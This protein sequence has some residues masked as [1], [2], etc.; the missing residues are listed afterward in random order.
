[1]SW[2]PQKEGVEQIVTCFANFKSEDKFVQEQ[3]SN[4]Y[5]LKDYFLF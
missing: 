5:K 1:M 2:E 4:V 3:I